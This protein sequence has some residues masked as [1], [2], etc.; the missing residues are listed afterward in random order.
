MNDPR[1]AAELA[2]GSPEWIDA[3]L[4]EQLGPEA[5]AGTLTFEGALLRVEGARLP[6]GALR[7]EVRSAAIELGAGAPIA[8]F[9]LRARLVSLHGELHGPGARVTAIS[10]DATP[11]DAARW[12]HGDLRATLGPEL[13]LEAATDLGPGAAGGVAGSLALGTARSQVTIT[14]AIDAAGR[15]DGSRVG[16]RLSLADAVAI[17]PAPIV[18]GPESAL[19]LDLAVEG[20]VADPRVR[21][22]VFAVA[23]TIGAPAVPSLVRLAEVAASIDLDRRRLRYEGLRGLA[24]GGRFGGF[25]R[26]SF[27]APASGAEAVP[28]AALQIDRVDASLFPALAALAG[29]PVRLARSGRAPPGEVWIPPDL[30]LTGELMVHPDLAAS[31]AFALETK[32]TELLLRVSLARGRDLLGSTLR[33]RLAIADALT[34][35]F[36]PDPVR[37]HPAGAFE[38]DARLGGTLNRPGLAGRVSIARLLLAAGEDPALPAF[39]LEDLSTVLDV[40]AE[41]FAWHKLKGRFCEGV[42]A[43]SGRAA[44]S[45]LNATVGWSG[46]RVELVPT[47]ASGTSALAT[48][49][50]GASAGELRFERD[51]PP[52]RPIIGRGGTQLGDPTYFFAK[53]LAPMLERYGLPAIRPRGRGPLQARLVLGPGELLVESLQAAADGIEVGGDVRVGRDGRLAGRIAVHLLEEYL[54]QSVMLALPAAVAGRVT[55]PVDLGG[56]VS[57]PEIRTDA[58]EILEGLLARNRV[59]D[60]VKGVVDGILGAIPGARRGR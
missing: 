20:P 48:L 6:L 42:F 60:V 55:I 21:G 39:V 14:L 59:N 5:A 28:L 33:G 15:A 47:D 12:A 49:I 27:G 18:I 17:V 31:G 1:P 32:R 11:T 56:T 24:F 53:K 38:I 25:G 9:P 43:S 30:T 54:R 3:R 26:V 41:R 35:G 50:H 45:G 36:F 46:V 19:D 10:F 52:Y 7:F 13:D 22:Q 34:L 16:G 57:A 29:A 37:P 40:D 4:R 58:M 8:D 23:L 44:A 51:G 2:V